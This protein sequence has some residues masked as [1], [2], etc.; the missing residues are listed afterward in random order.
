MARQC[1]GQAAEQLEW[2]RFIEVLPRIDQT[3]ALECIGE[4]PRRAEREEE[5]THLHLQGKAL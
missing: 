4:R 2:K 1:T 5:R 3:G